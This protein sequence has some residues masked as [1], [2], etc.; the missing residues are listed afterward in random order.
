M[1]LRMR[2]H[3]AFPIS[4][5]KVKVRLVSVVPM[6]LPH[7]FTNF[8]DVTVFNVVDDWVALYQEMQGLGLLR[9]SHESSLVSLE[10]LLV[11]LDQLLL[12]ADLTEFSN[13]EWQRVC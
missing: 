5:D 2:I 10:L 11:K 8:G 13:L 9:N 7:H 12:Q 6:A 1:G 3:R 4:A